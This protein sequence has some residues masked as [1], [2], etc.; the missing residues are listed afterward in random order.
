MKELIP[1]IKDGI[2]IEP[3]ESGYEIFTVMTQHFDVS[4]LDELTPERFELAIKLLAERD[5]ARTEMFSEIN[6]KI[7]IDV[8]KHIVESL[9]ALANAK[10][11][12]PK[13]PKYVMLGHTAMRLRTINGGFGDEPKSEYYRDGGCWSC[14]FR[15]DPTLNKWFS[16]TPFDGMD[17]I[18]DKELVPCT[19]EKWKEDNAGYI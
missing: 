7:K 10:R 11:K 19:K 8:D 12:Q 16:V 1:Y 15:Y 3:I 9:I 2:R 4:T 5:S 13:P 14:E 6:A 17:H 18:H